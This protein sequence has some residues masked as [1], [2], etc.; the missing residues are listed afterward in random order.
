MQGLLRSLWDYRFFILSSIKNDFHSRF[1]RS[2]LGGF[3]VILQPLSQVLI[4]AFILSNLLSSRIQG[5]EGPY[6]YAIYLMAGLLAWNLFTEV[7]DRC[8]KVFVSNANTMKKVKFPRIALPIIAIGSSI[9]NNVVLF[10]LINVIFL[11]LGHAVTPLIGFYFL[12]VPIV[13]I[14]AAGTGIALGVINVFVRDIEQV[15][16]III[17]VLFWFTPIVYPANVVPEAYTKILSLSP[18]YVL[19]E[20]YHAIFVFGTVPNLAPLAA[21]TALGLA[22]CGLALFLFRRASADM[23]DVL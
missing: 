14:L 9:V 19:V 23:V 20:S 4:Y 21:V 1:V 18:I 5:V 11:A 22:L 15:V 12:L 8:M 17:Q 13:A 16:P 2:K 3:W 6:G 7:L 10:V